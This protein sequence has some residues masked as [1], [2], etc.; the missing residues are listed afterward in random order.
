MSKY[1]E[2]IFADRLTILPSSYL[3][4]H[5][6]NI[7][8]QLV[9]YTASLSKYADPLLDILDPNHVRITVFMTCI[10]EGVDFCV[11]VFFSYSKL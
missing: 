10:R 11:C 4:I 6:Y 2:V 8:M 9:I 1:Y 7:Y 5:T 3:Y